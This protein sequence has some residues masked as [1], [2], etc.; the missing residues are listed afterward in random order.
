MS[1]ETSSIEEVFEEL[2]KRE[3]K[4][5]ERPTPLEA[6][7][8]LIDKICEVVKL[9]HEIKFKESRYEKLRKELEKACT[10]LKM[11]PKP[12]TKSTVFAES[13]GVSIAR[14]FVQRSPKVKKEGM[15]PLIKLFLSKVPNAPEFLKIS[16]EGI[17]SALKTGNITQ[18]EIAPHTE[19]GGISVTMKF[20]AS[21]EAIEAWKKRDA[22]NIPF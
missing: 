1:Q 2:A 10:T 17:N 14:T 7:P 21:A 16:W 8:D 3:V 15:I 18:E 12:K 11:E 4:P 5:L 20:F 22:E 9:E 6:Q 19:P 13:E